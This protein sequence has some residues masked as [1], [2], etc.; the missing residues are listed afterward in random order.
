[1]ADNPYFDFEEWLAK[2]P[3]PRLAQPKEVSDLVV[4]L[5]SDASDYSTGA[6]FPLDGGMTAG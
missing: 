5:A 4:Y 6:I 1:M 2:Q 3:V